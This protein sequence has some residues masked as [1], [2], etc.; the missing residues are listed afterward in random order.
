VK[1]VNIGKL[2]DK[3][4]KLG[5]NTGLTPALE[6]PRTGKIKIPYNV[7]DELGVRIQRATEE[8]WGSNKG[9][10][11]AIPNFS[12]ATID[13]RKLTDYALNP[14]HPVGGNKAKVSESALG[15]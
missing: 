15:V 1:A 5:V 11:N 10:D 13:P 2:A 7:R 9:I 14:N 4:E 8:R 12:K 3:V 6:I